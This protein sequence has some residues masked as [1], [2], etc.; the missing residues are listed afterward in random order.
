MNYVREYND[1][2]QLEVANIFQIYKEV[3]MNMSE[4]LI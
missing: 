4:V 3:I 2:K 1:L